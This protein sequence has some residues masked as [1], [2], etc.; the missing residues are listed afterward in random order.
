MTIQQKWLT[1][2]SLPLQIQELALRFY[3]CF[4][5][6]EGWMIGHYLRGNLGLGAHVAYMKT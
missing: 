2:Y 6:V 1:R 4:I 3:Q 5:D